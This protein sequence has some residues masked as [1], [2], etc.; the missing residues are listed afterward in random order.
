MTKRFY[1]TTLPHYAAYCE[2][3]GWECTAKNAQ[4]LAAQHHDRTGHKVTVEVC[5][6]IVYEKKED[7]DK[8]TKEMKKKKNSKSKK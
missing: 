5:R 4:G 3:C 6:T 2:V 7:Y 8:W 1:W